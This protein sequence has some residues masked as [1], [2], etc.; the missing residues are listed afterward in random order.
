MRTHRVEKGK[1]DSSLDSF[2]NGSVKKNKT[3]HFQMNEAWVYWRDM[4]SQSLFHFDRFKVYVLLLFFV[5]FFFLRPTVSFIS[6]IHSTQH[7]V[8][9][10]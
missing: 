2:I 7:I 9:L 10:T 4:Q 1:G 6:E 3:K 8:Y 5:F